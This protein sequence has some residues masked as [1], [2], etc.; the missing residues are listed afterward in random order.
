MS[1]IKAIETRYNG[2]RFRSRLEARWAVTFDHLG[3]KYLYELEGF[4]LAGGLCYLPDF[5]LP[6]MGLY[7]ELKPTSNFAWSDL[8][9]MAAFSADGRQRLLLI[10]GYPGKHDLRLLDST[11][12]FDL[13]EV[14]GYVDEFGSEDGAF[15]YVMMA[16]ARSGRVG[17]VCDER[18]PPQWRF[19]R[20]EP[21]A[22]RAAELAMALAKGSESRFEHGECG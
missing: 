8:R 22:Y 15:D 16:N 12:M 10:I 18:T 21:P 14:D 2:H 6:D 7:V 20:V 1:D 4:K 19:I 9:K 3:I 11:S 17:L 13:D 5:Y